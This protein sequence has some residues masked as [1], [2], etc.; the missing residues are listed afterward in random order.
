MLKCPE[1]GI[2]H[3][4]LTNFALAVV[5]FYKAEYKKSSHVHV[6][7]YAGG[8]IYKEQSKLKESGGGGGSEGRSFE[9]KNDKQKCLIHQGMH[10]DEWHWLV[11]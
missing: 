3:K 10:R 4:L 5:P 6:L 7:C 1:A 11:T 9:R 2:A 8:N